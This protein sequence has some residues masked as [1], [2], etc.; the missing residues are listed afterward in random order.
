MASK[1]FVFIILFF[2][3]HT[4]LKNTFQAMLFT[5]LL[6]IILTSAKYF[7][8]MGTSNESHELFTLF[9]SKAERYAF[10]D[11]M[12]KAN[13]MCNNLASNHKNKAY[14]DT[15]NSSLKKTNNSLNTLLGKNTDY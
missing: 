14:C 15:Y 4:Y 13:S 9:N 10:C 5:I 11:Q 2:P 12:A 8:I 1:V 3:L 7:H 6:L